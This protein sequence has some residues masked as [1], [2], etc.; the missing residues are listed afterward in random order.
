MKLVKKP[1]TEDVKKKKNVN[2]FKEVATLIWTSEEDDEEG[3][4]A[5]AYMN[6]SMMD[7]AHFSAC[8]ISGL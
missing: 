8:K 7:R 1:Q 4:I 6:A 2:K 5:S 3:S